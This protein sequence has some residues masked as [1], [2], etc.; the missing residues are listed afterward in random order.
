MQRCPSG[1]Y[2][3]RGRWRDSAKITPAEE[4]IRKKKRKENRKEKETF[5]KRALAGV[6]QLVGALF[7]KLK[8]HRLDSQSEHIPRL[9]V[10]P[11]LGHTR[12]QLINV[13][14]SVSLSPSSSLSKSN[15]KMSS[16]EDKKK[17]HPPASAK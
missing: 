10:D 9:Q 14:L 17:W 12:R 1:R 2:W 11:W 6:A 15:E 5:L 4:R 3:Y 8:G 16:G 13:S 7:C